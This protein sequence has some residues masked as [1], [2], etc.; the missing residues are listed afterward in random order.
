MKLPP[1]TNPNDKLRQY[2]NFR[3]D[4]VSAFSM[5]DSVGD[6]LDKLRALRIKMGSSIDKHI[7][8]FKLLA[9]AAEI[10]P[11]HALMIK[12]FKEMLQPVLRT[13]MMNLE[14]LLKNLNNWYTWAIRL[15]H[16]YHKS[17]Q[18]IDRTKENILKKPTPRY[19]FP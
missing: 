2:A 7:A 11:N 18:A 16:Q 15:D 3:K 12:L 1:S 6:A 13:Q 9:A 8:R 5:F 10:N 14:T 4:L 17:H 19:Y